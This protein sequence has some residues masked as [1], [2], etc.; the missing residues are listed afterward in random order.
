M[1]F[2]WMYNKIIIMIEVREVL[3]RRLPD[4]LFQAVHRDAVFCLFPE[5]SATLSFPMVRGAG[6]LVEA[7]V[8]P[9]FLIALP[10]GL[11]ERLRGLRSIEVLGT[12]SVDIERILDIAR[13][14]VE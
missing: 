6:P 12:L 13:D 8:A 7:A 9:A 10:T 2:V 1:V 11:V 5:V 3:L 14:G 4:E